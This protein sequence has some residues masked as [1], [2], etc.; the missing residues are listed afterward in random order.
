M[1][2]IF[3]KYGWA[4]RLAVIAL[5]CLLLAASI[6]SLIASQ[7]LAPYTV[8][9]TPDIRAQVE[10]ESEKQDRSRTRTPTVDRVDAITQ[11]CFFGCPETSED[12]KKTCPE[13]CPEGQECVDGA[14]VEAQPIDPAILSDL[15][16]AS[17]LNVKLMGVMVTD[18]GEWS[19]ALMQE[20]EDKKTYI[21][22]PGDNLMDEAT[23]VEIKR[24][25]IILDNGGQ[26]EFIRLQNTIT[27]DPSAKTLARRRV[28][29]PIA[30]PRAGGGTPSADDQPPSKD[31]A[32]R[33]SP[34]SEQVQQVGDGRYK[35]QREAVEKRMENKKEL[36]KGASIIPNYRDGKKNG[37]KLINITNDSVYKTLGL[38][39]GDVLQSVNGEEIRSQAHAM[40]LM[41]K[42]QKADRV[43][44]TIE[45][46]GKRETMNYDIK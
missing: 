43:E 31:G 45:R 40:E 5:I 14:C 18:P 25:R 4:I 7:L 46:N 32:A 16:V 30:A 11:R 1:E 37:L 39:S 29:T 9:H 35:L 21:V 33:R 15:P 8:P 10:Q 42:F 13:E 41:E 23:V 28:S 2:N 38:R 12:D 24:D 44:L 20:P 22:S 36:A 26:L 34:S 27:G 19:S 3:R 17:D 6:N